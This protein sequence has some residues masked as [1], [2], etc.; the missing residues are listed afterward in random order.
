MNDFQKPTD[1]ELEILRIL[2]KNK[3]STVREVHNE[4]C[5]TK[6]AGYTNTLKLMQIMHD[7]NL[8]T[9]DSS[10]KTHIYKANITQQQTQLKFLPKFIDNLFSGSATQLVMQT[11]GNHQPSLQEINEIEEMLNNLKSNHKNG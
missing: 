6:D 7:K 1:S 11:L 5:F 4:L 9:R 2:W 8:V 10:S 3:A